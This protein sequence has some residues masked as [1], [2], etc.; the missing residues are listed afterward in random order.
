MNRHL[1]EVTGKDTWAAQDNRCV[2]CRPVAHVEDVPLTEAD[3]RELNAPLLA[4]LIGEVGGEVALRASISMVA[5]AKRAGQ[6]GDSVQGRLNSPP[7]STA[8]KSVSYDRHL[9]ELPGRTDT[10]GSPGGLPVRG[11]RQAC[12]R[13]V[14]AAVRRLHR[15]DV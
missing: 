12:V 7:G 10:A 15:G 9:R 3:V 6:R 4:D 1:C 5:Q 13:S 14:L 11:V 8:T 2:R